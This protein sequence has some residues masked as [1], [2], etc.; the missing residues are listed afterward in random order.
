METMSVEIET[1][2]IAKMVPQ[3][4][5]PMKMKFANLILS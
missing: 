5:K 4:V 3:N 2:L 1:W